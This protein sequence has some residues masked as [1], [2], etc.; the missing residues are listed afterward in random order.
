MTSS[1]QRCLLLFAVLA[2]LSF[3]PQ[4]RA[5]TLG[6]TVMKTGR[7]IAFAELVVP[8]VRFGF[9]GERT[10]LALAWPLVVGLGDVWF[11][12]DQAGAFRV[13]GG[14]SELGSA[15]YFSTFLEPQWEPWNAHARGLFGFRG[16]LHRDAWL[17]VAFAV[18]AGGLG[19]DVGP[20]GFVG[21]YAGAEVFG[22]AL[23]AGG[24]RLW[25]WPGAEWELTVD[26]M[27]PMQWLTVG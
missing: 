5:A 25:L 15:L 24:R 12:K 10:R 14:C 4:S 22:I 8:D 21:A 20:G 2:S 3:A 17:P 19:G 23:L 18:E 1:R 7:S 11:G 13:C 16:L 6:E 27:V 9:G 26:L